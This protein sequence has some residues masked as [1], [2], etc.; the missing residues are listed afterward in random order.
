M[1]TLLQ[2]ADRAVIKKDWRRTVGMFDADP[3]MQAII[4]EG[5]RIREENRRQNNK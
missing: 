5:Q 4:E 1:Q 2:S 3:L